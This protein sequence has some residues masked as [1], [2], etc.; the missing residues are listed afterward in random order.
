MIPCFENAEVTITVL[1]DCPAC[2]ELVTEP[3]KLKIEYGPPV[4]ANC[5]ETLSYHRAITEY[6]K[7]RYLC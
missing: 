1:P 5:L 7:E 4:L 6:I 2:A 3:A